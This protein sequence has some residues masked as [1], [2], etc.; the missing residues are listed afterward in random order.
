M[1][2]LT[3]GLDNFEFELLKLYNRGSYPAEIEDS[4]RDIIAEVRRDG[5]KALVKFAKKF[6]HADLTPDFW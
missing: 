3:Y 4:V 6:D 1:K 2:R 5:D